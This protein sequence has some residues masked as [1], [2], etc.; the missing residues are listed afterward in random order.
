MVRAKKKYDSDTYQLLQRC[1]AI[2]NDAEFEASADN[3]DQPIL[4]RACVNGN[5]TDFGTL[6]FDEMDTSTPNVA[7]LSNK[8]QVRGKCTPCP[9]SLPLFEQ[10]QV[11]VSHHD[12]GEGWC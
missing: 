1:A 12:R 8:Y 3:I 6:K 7:K 11:H 9:A 5:A 2:C 4:K 10:I